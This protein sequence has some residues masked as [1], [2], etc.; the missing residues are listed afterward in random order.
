MSAAWRRKRTLLRQCVS[1]DILA[2]AC[3]Q[4]HDCIVSHVPRMQVAYQMGGTS[5]KGRQ[6]RIDACMEA[7]SMTRH[8]AGRTE[9]NCRRTGKEEPGRTPPR[10]CHAESRYVLVFHQSTYI[11]KYFEYHPDKCEY[12]EGSYRV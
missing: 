7:R 1:I 10:S 9:Q 4:D 8:G 3:Q 2:D 6:C 5:N 12:L 11:P